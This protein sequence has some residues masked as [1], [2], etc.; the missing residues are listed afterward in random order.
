MS[1][2]FSWGSIEGFI[3]ERRFFIEVFLFSK[4][5]AL[6]SFEAGKWVELLQAIN[7]VALKEMV[8]NESVIFFMLP[9][10]VEI[11]DQRI[12]DWR[13]ENLVDWITTIYKLLAEHRAK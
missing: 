3:I 10:I 1:A 8:N 13:N 4:Y 9:G 6:A 7:A 12:T 11:P 5:S 2:T